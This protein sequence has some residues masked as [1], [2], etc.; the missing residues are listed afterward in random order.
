MADSRG[1]CLN[2]GLTFVNSSRY[3][4]WSGGCSGPDAD[5]VKMRNILTARG[6]APKKLENQAATTA[7]VCEELKAMADRAVAGDI[8]V[9]SF[10]GHGGQREDFNGDEGDGKDETLCLYDGHLIDDALSELLTEFKEMV[11]VVTVCDSCNSGSVSE[12]PVGLRHFS[13][14]EEGY[15][16]IKAQV[17]HVAGCRD[18]EESV[19]NA[20]G[21][22]L[23][24]SIESALNRG[25]FSLGY[26]G[27][28]AQVQANSRTLLASSRHYQ[29]PQLVQVANVSE[30]FLA[31]QPFEI[32]APTGLKKI[33]K[34]AGPVVVE[35]PDE[36]KEK[37]RKVDESATDLLRMVNEFTGET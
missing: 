2:V 10:S 35:L 37:M 19:G 14:S 20:R 6:F 26:R 31:Q 32:E 18:G 17:L 36:L 7:N 21:G 4:G 24:R 15:K 30:A 16:K 33:K 11:R 25:S 1:Y 34:T 9:F 8:C 29:A 23:T 28:Y 13:G 3:R 5:I 12:K 27:F 22:V